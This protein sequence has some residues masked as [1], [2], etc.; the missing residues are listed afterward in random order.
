MPGFTDVFGGNTIY[1]AQPTYLA[2]ALTAN[3]TLE[4]PIELATTSLVLAAIIDVTASAPGFNITFPDARQGSQGYVATIYNAGANS[5]NVVDAAGG[6]IVT[7]ASGEAWNIY[8]TNNTTL[9]GAW[10]TFQMGA[11]TSSANAAALAGAGLVAISTTLNEEMEVLNKNVNYIVV[12]A[13]RAKTV[14]WTGGIG[15]FTLPDPVTVGTN[16]FVVAKNNGS[17]S[18]TITPASGTIDG[19]TNLIL[20]VN[21]STY[22]VSDGTNYLTVGRGQRTTGNSVFD[23]IS[24]NVSG[25]GDYTLSGAQLNRVAY[26]FTGV[27]TGNRNI[28]VPASVQQYWVTNATSGAFSLTIKASGGDPGTA[29]VQG[30]SAILYCNGTNVI[31]A[32]TFNGVTFLD[33]SAPSPSITFASGG[34]GLYKFAANALGFSTNGAGRGSIGAN[35][36]WA[37]S[38]VTAGAVPTLTVNKANGVIGLQVTSAATQAAATPGLVVKAAVA[39]GVAGIAIV[40]KNGTLGTDDIALYQDGV[41]SGYLHNRDT[42]VGAALRFKVG[43]DEVL[44]LAK[45]GAGCVALGSGSANSIAF[46]TLT[47]TTVGAA[48][49]ASALPA[50]PVGYMTVTVN[51]G[52]VKIPFYNP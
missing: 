31:P 34:A 8:L 29:V 26:E 2:L 38:A 42:A 25:T 10:R 33:G 46:S 51:G 19:S 9:A 52:A 18:L 28:I 45:A 11:G 41:Q 35:G 36:E 12:D 5:F 7:V 15:S 14:T 23:F 32:E 1:P 17:G 16:W 4:W 50:S 24:I 40:G 39:A 20:T 21:E 47:Q 22:L 48:G 49:G 6:A 3:T 27:L 43:N 13:D 44:T 37:M 30:A